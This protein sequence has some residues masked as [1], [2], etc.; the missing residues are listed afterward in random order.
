MAL[1]SFRRKSS[2][3]PE[4][5]ELEETL[6]EARRT[7]ADA[8]K[9]QAGRV[10]S[11]R[12]ELREAER[13]HE[14]VVRD[15][16]SELGRRKQE[17]EQRIQHAQKRYDSI[18]ATLAPMEVARF[19]KTVLYEDRVVSKQ[20]EALLQ[21]GVTALA[22]TAARIAIAR[23]GAVARLAASGTVNGRAFRSVQG[24][25]ARR[26]YLLIEAPEL[27][28]LL[29]CRAGDE[30]AAKEFATR[31]NVAALNARR[32]EREREETIGDAQHELDSAESQQDA[33]LSADDELARV[34]SDTEHIDVARARLEDAESD[35]ATIT[36]HAERV[37]ELEQEFA[38]ATAAAQA[39]QA[40]VKRL[41][42]ETR[43]EEKRL[44][45]EAKDEERRLKDEAKAEKKRLEDEEAEDQPDTSE[46]AEADS[47]D[48]EDP[49]AEEPSRETVVI[50]ETVET[51]TGE[52]VGPDASSEDS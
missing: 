39:S 7:F 18:R 9:E 5:Q 19:G 32:I 51:S 50:M 33:V 31:I 48:A 46:K 27:V 28:A 23:P 16:E 2:V 3:S 30:S 36:A 6:K 44:K 29:P 17:R 35:T 47:S 37:E 24:Y 42:D 20:G 22:D 12:K 15:A 10:K 14:R 26:F 25:D 43:A 13:E 40:E 45:Q 34:S 41:E 52:D 49:P 8:R 38:L 21:R 4:L 1:R 11:I